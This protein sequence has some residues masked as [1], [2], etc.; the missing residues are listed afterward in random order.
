MNLFLLHLPK[1]KSPWNNMKNIEL[2]FITRA[3]IFF[4]FLKLKWQIPGKLKDTQNPIHLLIHTFYFFQF[5]PTIVI[6]LFCDWRNKPSSSL[7][8]SLIYGLGSELELFASNFDLFPPISFCEPKLSLYPHSWFANFTKPL[9]FRIS[10]S[11][12]II[13]ISRLV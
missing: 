13:L 5:Y 1:S 2:Y 3:Q 11:L 12:M 6:L 8:I 7:I 9:T 10:D 4:S